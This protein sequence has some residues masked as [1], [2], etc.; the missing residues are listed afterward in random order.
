MLKLREQNKFCWKMWKF[1]VS[2]AT[3]IQTISQ[4]IFLENVSN[5]WECEACEARACCMTDPYII[6]SPDPNLLQFGCVDKDHNSFP[7][8]IL[9]TV[10]FPSGFRSGL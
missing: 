10:I 2:D 8:C 4:P 5:S 1:A 7:I 3:L 9:I 6:L